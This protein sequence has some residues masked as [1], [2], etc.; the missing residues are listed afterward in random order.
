VE[1]LG[2]RVADAGAAPGADYEGQHGDNP[3]LAALAS[4]GSCRLGDRRLPVITI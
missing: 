4:T 2:D 3:P 1:G